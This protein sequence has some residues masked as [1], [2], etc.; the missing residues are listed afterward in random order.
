MK[1]K[2]DSDENYIKF[3]GTAGARF[4]VAKQLRSSAGVFIKLHG[5]NIILDPGPGTLVR[6]AK[7]KPPIDVEKLDAIILSHIHIDHSNDVNILIDAMTAGGFKKRGLLFAP[8]ECIEG[9]NSVILKYL[10]DFLDDII[11]LK[12]DSE[13][14][15]NSLRFKTSIRH[16]HQAETY[17][18][19]FFHNNKVISF[20]VDTKFFP[21]LIE[22]YK[23]SDL[24]I[25][26]VVRYKPSKSDALMHLCIDDVRKIVSEIKPKKVILTHFGMTMIRAKPYEI[27][28]KLS[29]ELHTEIVA[30]SDGMAISLDKL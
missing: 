29:G 3:L 19:K 20:M 12:E 10:R 25:I 22:N 9:E 11:I 2:L 1:D 16:Q 21:E 26:N 14:R 15:I 17:G 30:A 5:K 4:V 8:I 6:C 28:N 7:S 24:L 13:Y 23:D 18:I 27:A